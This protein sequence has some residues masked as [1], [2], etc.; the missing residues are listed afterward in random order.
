[1]GEFISEDDLE[2]FE[3]WLKYQRFAPT[4]PEEESEMRRAFEEGRQQR[5]PKVGLMKTQ[6][7]PR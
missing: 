3:G 2:T 5:P 7:G 6:A 1:M 4:T